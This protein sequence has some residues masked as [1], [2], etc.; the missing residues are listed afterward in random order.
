MARCARCDC[1]MDVVRVDSMELDEC[2]ECGGIWFD[3]DELMGVV[4]LEVEKL[5]GRP[6]M[7]PVDESVISLESPPAFC[8][9]C[10]APLDPHRFDLDLAVIMDVCPRGHG[11]WLDRGE[12]VRIK[13]FL[14]QADARDVRDSDQDVP[15][16]R[17]NIERWNALHRDDGEDFAARLKASYSKIKPYTKHRHYPGYTWF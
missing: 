9:R 15:R 13:E 6:E 3:I 8:P 17:R 16:I 4:H 10:S 14:D 11:L 7:D 1:E 12:L 2:P 5:A